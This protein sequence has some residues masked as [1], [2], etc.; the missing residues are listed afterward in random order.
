M[1]LAASVAA[2]QQAPRSGAQNT[3][4]FLGLGPAP[5][6]AAAERGATIYAA[7]C[8]FCHGTKATGGDTG[9]DLLRSTVVLHDQKGETVA[10]VIRNGRPERGMPAFAALS[11]AQLYDLAEFLHMRV[12]LTANRGTYQYL[13]AVH[14][15]SKA[16]EAYFEGAGQCVRC[17]SVTG[18]LAHVGSKYSAVD[19]Q[20]RF[21]YPEPRREAKEPPNAKI[22]LSSSETI[23]GKLRYL[24]DFLAVIEQG[25]GS[26][27]TIRRDASVQ[28]TV[29]DPLASHR[30]LLDRYKDSDIHN[31]T[32]YLATLK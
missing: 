12:E 3:R 28:I 19:L 20:Q 5:D 27:R 14:G 32:A 30:E 23:S 1:M 9:P 22:T 31:L 24:D 6:A 11:G 8:T 26:T 2:A 16:G 15:D 18:D 25:N 13:N 7:N 17:H 21:L 10:P 29:D 4:D